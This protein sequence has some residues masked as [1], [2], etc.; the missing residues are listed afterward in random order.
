MPDLAKHGY[1]DGSGKIE[2]IPAAG[3]EVCCD[4]A[5]QDGRRGRERICV[6]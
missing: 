1:L 4:A 2:R 3:G 5:R 6:A